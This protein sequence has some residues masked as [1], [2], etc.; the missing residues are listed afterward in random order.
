M[1]SNIRPAIYNDLP[2][3]MSIYGIA[4]DFMYSTGNIGQWIDGY[5]TEQFIS[6]EIKAGHSF[7][8][9]N[10]DGEIAGTFCFIIGEDP[11][12][13]KIFDGQW[14][15]NEPYGTVHRIASSGKVR[16]VAR[17]CFEWC[18]TQ[19]QNIRVDTYKKNLVMQ[20]ILKDLEFQYC[21]IIFLSD[22]A[23]R[24]AFQKIL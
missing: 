18:F 4:R 13:L 17:A 7:V 3:I 1:I 5:P 21:G 10:Q 24:L 23:E 16:G 2:E 19:C 9:E 12:Y 15:N 6:E 14:L 22:G 8:C 11:T 20:H